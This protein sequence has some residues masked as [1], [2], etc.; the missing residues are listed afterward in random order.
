MLVA[1]HLAQLRPVLREMA[2]FT[3]LAPALG[4]ALARAYVTS[5]REVE[6]TLQAWHAECEATRPATFDPRTVAPRDALLMVVAHAYGAMSYE[7]PGAL[8]AEAGFERLSDIMRREPH[9]RVRAAVLTAIGK[10]ARTRF[11]RVERLL[12]RL[13]QHVTRA[14]REQVVRL[15]LTVF[16]DQRAALEGGDEMVEIGGRRYPVWLTAGRPLTAVEGAMVRWAREA[17]H[18][19]AQPLALQASI[20]F[21]NTVDRHE[22]VK[23]AELRAERLEQALADDAALLPGAP[24]HM[25]PL[26]PT[27]YTAAFVPW[28]AT[29]R[30]PAWRPAVSGLLPEVLSQNSTDPAALHYVL[31][32]WRRLNGD[33]D[34]AELAR[35]LG[36]AISWH[37][38]AWTLLAA[39]AFLVL[40]FLALLLPH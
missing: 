16:K 3:D 15:L 8:A 14:E 33:R 26:R 40:L 37:G 30:A 20:A 25:V 36:S 22:G 11:E 34:A 19:V 18:P 28:L 27:W 5:P 21:A 12:H 39:G 9:P 38:K 35:L 31:N 23:V 32:R 4:Q 13:V 17:G 2:A 29:L 7:G 10:Q 1:T 6:A 24:V